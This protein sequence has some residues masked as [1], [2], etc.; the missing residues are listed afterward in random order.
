MVHERGVLARR[1]R[2]RQ[3]DVDGARVAV[4]VVVV[5]VCV[6]VRCV[7]ALCCVQSASARRRRRRW[8][9]PFAVACVASPHQTR[10]VRI[11]SRPCRRPAACSRCPLRR[12]PIVEREMVGV[13]SEMCV[14]LLLPIGER[15]RTRTSSVA[16]RH[17]CCAHGGGLNPMVCGLGA[18]CFLCLRWGIAPAAVVSCACGRARAG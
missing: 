17:G 2:V 12:A 8:P 13:M 14:F 11:D 10:T 7:R 18:E 15:A 4:V 5:V 1:R 6:C 9:P 16:M 3:H